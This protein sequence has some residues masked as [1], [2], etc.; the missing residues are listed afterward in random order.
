MSFVPCCHGSRCDPVW[1]VKWPVPTHRVE[2]GEQSLKEERWWKRVETTPSMDSA[3]SFL[4]NDDHHWTAM[5]SRPTQLPQRP[6]EQWSRHCLDGSSQRV[7]ALLGGMQTTQSWCGRFGRRSCRRSTTACWW[8]VGRL[9]RCGQER[10]WPLP[11][12]RQPRFLQAV[13]RTVFQGVVPRLVL[14]RGDGPE[15]FAGS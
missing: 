6:R 10:R 14:R 15:H 7:D 8:W 11:F 4:A 13:G 2:G 12:A 5:P 1:V 9:R 3:S